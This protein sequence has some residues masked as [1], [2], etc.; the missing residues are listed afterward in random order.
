MDLKGRVAFV[1][2]GSGGIGSSIVQALAMA[3]V[4][5]VVGFNG[6]HA[7]ALDICAA[8]KTLG[9]RAEAVQID[10]ADPGSAEAGVNRA[11]DSFGRLDILIN[12]AAWNIGIPFADLDA[13]TVEIWDKIFATNARGP[14]VLARAAAR[15]MRNQGAG[16]IVNIASVGGLIPAGSSI[17]YSCSKAAL[18]HLTR[19]LAVALGPEITVNCVAPGLVEGTRMA[20]RLPAE[21]IQMSKQRAVLKRTA[22]A[23]DVAQQVVAFCR[24]DSV[25]GQVLNIDGGMH[26][27]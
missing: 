7:A 17:A 22:S 6:N 27:H 10:Q 13:L 8:V 23:G 18:I 9:Q 21:V 12:N 14:F 11:A 2:G 16:R 25:T 15:H 24:S 5:V 3:G 4:D 19:C 26:F 1:T 20:E